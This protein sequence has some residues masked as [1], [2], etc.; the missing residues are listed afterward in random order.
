LERPAGG[1]LWKKWG[2]RRGGRLKKIAS[3]G[4][5]ENGFLLAGGAGAAQIEQKGGVAERGKAKEAAVV[6][7]GKKDKRKELG[8]EWEQRDIIPG[9]GRIEEKGQ[10]KQKKHARGGEGGRC[11]W[12]RRWATFSP[13]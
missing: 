7:G 9:E 12:L 2:G 8:R 6:S 1:M 13:P 10:K 5:K 11:T 3:N 4:T